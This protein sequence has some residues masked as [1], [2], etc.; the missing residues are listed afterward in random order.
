M[1]DLKKWAESK[2]SQPGL[3]AVARQHQHAEEAAA[4]ARRA[5]TLKAEGKHVEAAAAHREAGNSY[6]AAGHR[7]SAA[8][9]K[10]MADRITDPKTTAH[11]EKGDEKA[12]L[13]KR[14]T[15]AGKYER[16][17]VAHAAAAAAYKKAGDERQT[18]MHELASTR[19]ARGTEA[20]KAEFAKDS[21]DSGDS[22]GSY[23]H[24]KGGEK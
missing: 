21:G 16:A 12:S 7:E 15:K 11:R 4:H 18:K 9:H 1:S 14:L 19:Y 13:A 8:H 6:M 5:D 24:W 22:G 3:S 2:T 23:S 10:L 17:A 20:A